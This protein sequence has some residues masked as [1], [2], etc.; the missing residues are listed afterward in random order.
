LEHLARTITFNE[1]LALSKLS[2]VYKVPEKLEVKSQRKIPK[3]INETELSELNVFLFKLNK[4]E[5]SLEFC[6]YFFDSLERKIDNIIKRNLKENKQLKGMKMKIYNEVLI[7][8]GLCN[9]SNILL[10]FEIYRRIENLG[11]FGRGKEFRRGRFFN[12][13]AMVNFYGFFFESNSLL[14]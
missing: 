12:I 14:Y 11:E 6:K 10:I 8:S 1:F 3:F 9:N 7:Q 4:Y 5:L 13:E 2:L